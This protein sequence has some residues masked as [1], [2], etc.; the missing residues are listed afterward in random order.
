MTHDYT[1]M[2]QKFLH[3]FLQLLRIVHP[4]ELTDL[5]LCLALGYDFFRLTVLS[6]ECSLVSVSSLFQHSST[7]GDKGHPIVEEEASY[8]IEWKNVGDEEMEM[9]IASPHLIQS[10]LPQDLHQ[11]FLSPKSSL[12][13]SQVTVVIKLFISQLCLIIQ[14]HL[15]TPKICGIYHCPQPR[16]Y[17]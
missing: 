17:L 6:N 10:S 11:S 2:S 8:H 13:A 14:R 9:P 1:S 5:G 3:L 12:S 16:N 7:Q 4:S 15:K